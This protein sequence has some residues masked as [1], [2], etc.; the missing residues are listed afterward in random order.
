MNETY[1]EWKQPRSHWTSCWYSCSLGSST[2]LELPMFHG[3]PVHTVNRQASPPGG[4]VLLSLWET[5]LQSHPVC[6]GLPR[7]YASFYASPWGS[8]QCLQLVCRLDLDIQNFLQCNSV[9]HVIF[10]GG[11]NLDESF[12]FFFFFTMMLLCCSRNHG[13]VR[14]LERGSAR[15]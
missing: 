12:F 4:C 7:C 11:N 13:R 5:L 3:T 2:S 14:N 8:R 15:T 10:W 1:S 6:L 9:Q